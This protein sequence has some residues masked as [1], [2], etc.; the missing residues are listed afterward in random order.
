[1]SIRQYVES[2][3][4]SLN[5]HQDYINYILTSIFVRHGIGARD[6]AKVN[7]YIKSKVQYIISMEVN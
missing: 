4:K 2:Q 7:S 5:L 1:M 3:V 6:G